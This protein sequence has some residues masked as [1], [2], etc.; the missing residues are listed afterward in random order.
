MGKEKARRA[1][2]GA[3]L[4]LGLV[5][6]HELAVIDAHATA[7][8]TNPR[9]PGSH[10]TATAGAA[11]DTTAADTTQHATVQASIPAQN[12]EAG[13]GLGHLCVFVLSAL[14]AALLLAPAFGTVAR[15]GIRS[16]AGA[17][18]RLGPPLR[19]PPAAGRELLNLV[20]CFRT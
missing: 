8:S 10:G 17:P 11:A 3:L 18:I 15:L 13:H 2:L 14:L 20:C 12:H 9:V 4:V 16:G 1:L 6:M 19:A 5:T 7:H